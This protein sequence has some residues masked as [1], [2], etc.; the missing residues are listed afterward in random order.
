VIDSLFADDSEWHSFYDAVVDALPEFDRKFTKEQLVVIFKSLPY[1]DQAVAL[2]W[3]LSD[4]CFRDSAFVHIRAHGI[5]NLTE[6][7]K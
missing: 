1:A 6:D 2:A 5:P 4:T 3:G 7:N